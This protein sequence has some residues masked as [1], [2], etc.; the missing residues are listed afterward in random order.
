[1]NPTVKCYRKIILTPNFTVQYILKTE[2]I[3]Y[4][5]LKRGFYSP[6]SIVYLIEICLECTR[7]VD[8][9]RG[10]IRPSCASSEI[11]QDAPLD[12]SP[13][14]GV[15]AYGWTLI[16]DTAID[17]RVIDFPSSDVPWQLV[18]SQDDSPLLWC[19]YQK[20]P[21]AQGAVDTVALTEREIRGM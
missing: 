21:A 19:I 7:D 15:F 3:Y 4:I 9:N 8:L 10:W 18:V 2:K 13:H 16:S 11:H 1:M 17:G 5:F 12:V 14:L 20:L 6:L